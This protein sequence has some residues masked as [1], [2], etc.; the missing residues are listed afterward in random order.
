MYDC[1]TFKIYP[2]F[3][4]LSYS[5]RFDGGRRR[6]LDDHWHAADEDALVLARREPVAGG[7]EAELGGGVVGHVLLQGHLLLHAVVEGHDE[8]ARV[9]LV[10]AIGR[11]RHAEIAR[12]QRGGGEVERRWE[13][14]CGACRTP[15]E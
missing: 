3:L 11:L 13:Q 10:R 8:H 15:R 9:R 6:R 12:A 4:K 5:P 1:Y 7:R 2:F 14:R